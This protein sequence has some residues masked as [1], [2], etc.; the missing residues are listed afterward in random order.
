MPYIYGTVVT[1]LVAIVL[2]FFIGVGGALFL[3]ELA[4]RRLCTPLSTLVELFAAIPSVVYG[5]WGIF[6]FAPLMR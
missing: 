4:L 5:L 3:T 1:S 6:V 2:A